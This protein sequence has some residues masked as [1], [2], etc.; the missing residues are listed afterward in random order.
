[1][2]KI[3]FGVIVI[4][5]FPLCINA[6]DCPNS[7]KERLQKLSNNISVVLEEQA[8]GKIMTTFSGLSDELK[9]YSQ[10]DYSNHYNTLDSEMGETIIKNLKNGKTYQFK[11]YG[12]SKCYNTIVR[13][14][15]INTPN[16][17]PYYG[18]EICNNALEYSLCQK[19]ASVDMNYD[20][21]KKNVSEYIKNNKSNNSYNDDKN[22][23]NNKTISFLRFYEKYYWP[24]FA[25]LICILGLL[26]FLWVK[27]NKKNKL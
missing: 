1:M 21:F 22:E 6:D 19:W 12:Y 16:L 15:T 20:D 17:N 25:G 3:I 9:I 13:I 2:R 24:T 27:E 11:V 7:Y 14:I 10:I 5:I 8:D 26:V 18:D 4:L 23:S